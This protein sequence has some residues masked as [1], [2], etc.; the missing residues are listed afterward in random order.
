MPQTSPSLI[1]GPVLYFRGMSG[2]RA[3][4]A[5]LVVTAADQQPL[6]LRVEDTAVTAQR[7]TS[8]LAK[9][10]WRYRFDVP[11]DRDDGVTYAIGDQHWRIYPPNGEAMRIAYTACNGFEH[12]NFFSDANSNRNERWRHLGAEHAKSPFQLLIQGGDQLY[13]DDVWR[14]V[15]ELAAWRSLKQ[16]AQ[17]TARLS[18]RAEAA[19]RDFY[20]DSYCQLWAQPDLAPV[21]ASIPSVMM[22]DDHD[23]FDGWGSHPAALQRSPVFRSVWTVAREQFALFQ[24]A[25]TLDELPTM[26][27]D[28]EG[29]HFGWVVQINT[30]GIIAPDLRSQRTRS[31]VMGETGW[32]WMTAALAR[33]GQCQQVFFV[34]TVPVLNLNLSWLERLVE[35]LP[36]RHR[37]YQDDFRDQWRSYQHRHEWR[38]LVTHLL[39]F[40]RQTQTRVTI[41]SG[42]IHL[43]AVGVVERDATRVFQLTSSGVVHDPPPQL[44]ARVFDLLSRGSAM[45]SDGACMRMLPLP[46]LESRYLAARNWLALDYTGSSLKVEWHSEAE[47]TSM[48]MVIE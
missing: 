12:N 28:P 19:I 13:A 47:P 32:R 9:T 20:F 16:S 27:G 41:L 39:D 25:S 7:L 29:G 35:P 26:V 5:A 6:E 31:Q 18:P 24:L 2:T 38:R 10:V 43:G 45:V 46:R 22:W 8:G 15:P 21:V 23:I 40:S 48:P 4:L 14:E 44:L 37:L 42:E 34:S 3:N 36:V 11:T 17:V 1:T 30:T 33:L